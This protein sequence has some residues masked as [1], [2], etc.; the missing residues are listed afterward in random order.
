VGDA[1]GA[2]L[3]VISER[4]RKR[5]DVN[6]VPE[7]SENGGK[8]PT[9]KRRI[10]ARVGAIFHEKNCVEGKNS[11]PMRENRYCASAKIARRETF[12]EEKRSTKNFAGRGRLRS[13]ECG[14]RIFHRVRCSMISP[15]GAS[16]WRRAREGMFAREVEDAIEPTAENEIRRCCPGSEHRMAD[17]L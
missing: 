10:A 15:R 2:L 6:S 16:A 9:E 11:A 17:G 3:F 5:R 7:D 8:I 14:G 12:D 13:R 1:I 4:A